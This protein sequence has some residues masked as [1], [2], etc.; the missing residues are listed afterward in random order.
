MS[1][2]AEYLEGSSSSGL[3]LIADHASNHVPDDIELGIDPALLSEHIAV[4]IGIDALSRD[5]A[6]RLGCPAIVARVSRL[7]VDFNRRA[8]EPHAIPI[9]SDGHAVPGNAALGHEGRLARIEHFWTPYHALI[10]DKI[11]ALRPRMLLSLHSFTP[12]LAT[13]PEEERPWHVGLLYNQDDRA[14]RLA[15]AA[16]RRAGV[17][18]G[19]NQPYSG[20]LLNATMDRHAEAR[21]LP[22]LG[23]EVRQDLI[24]DAEG[25]EKWAATLASVVA[26]V[27]DAL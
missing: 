4:D 1:E 26:E 14:A 19:D 23:I 7:V 22:Y 24:A 2:A 11:D 21:G 6:A 20:R 18:T 25:V 3:L 17:P 10:A 8:D 9:A 5:L 16:L 13:R 27:R 15:I 12:T